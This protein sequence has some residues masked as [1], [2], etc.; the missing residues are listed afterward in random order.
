MAPD[1]ITIL[2]IED[3]PAHAELVRRAFQA[4]GDRFDLVTVSTLT[5]AFKLI[6]TKRPD[7]IITDWALPDGDGGRLLSHAQSNGDLPVIVMTSYGN[8]QTAVEAMRSGALD[9][10]VK[11]AE[12]MSD[13]PHVAERA[14]REWQ[15]VHDRRVAEEALRESEVRFRTLSENAPDIVYTLSHDGR[16]TY[17]NP[18]WEKI[19]GHPAYEVMGRPLTEFVAEEDRDDVESLLIRVCAGPDAIQ[20][21]KGAFLHKN[22]TRRI[23]LVSCGPNVNPEGRV[24]GAVGLLKD[25]TA[26][27]QLESQLLQSQKMEALGTLAGGVAHE[28]NNVL[29]AIKGYTQLMAIDKEMPESLRELLD[30]IDEAT[31]RARDLT[32]KLLTFSRI[33]SGVKTAVDINTV[34]NTVVD[35][36]L[37]TFPRNIKVQLNL[38]KD[39]GI[40]SANSTQLEQVVLNLSLNAKD[41]MPDGGELTFTTAPRRLDESFCRVNPWA[42]PGHYV[43]LSVADAGS[44]IAPHD[45]TRIFEPF[46]TTKEAEKGTGLGLSVAYS[47]IRSHSGGI[48]VDSRPANGTRFDLFFP[49]QEVPVEEV[50]DETISA[51]FIKGQGEHVLV[52]DDEDAVRE[53]T[54]SALENF[55]YQVD[56]ATNG[57]EALK[58]VQMAR[59]ADRPYHLILL[60]LAMPIMDGR[61][62]YHR[63]INQDA[64]PRILIA[65][66]HLSD[67]ETFEEKFPQAMGL[68]QKPFDLRTLLDEVHK[69]LV[70]PAN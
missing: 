51:P 59:D 31:G 42:T 57:A 36:I 44:G 3:E 11:S 56:E 7:L 29:T 28:F 22:G 20:G 40:I 33:E 4:S 8:E 39:I 65:T 53:V 19:L 54:R 38:D 26:T 32:R 66:G 50:P 61:E 14:L 16:F 25:I 27:I 30:K 5:G 10:V 46:Y 70:E 9:Y 64:P 13:M 12:A 35:L 37:H 52:V 6:E 45:V 69:T 17:V 68:L 23:F 1:P 24:T 18:A 55:G 48:L 58:A 34:V 49:I 47:I 41:A 15:L 67:R 60:D 43:V 2:L 62:C 63:L 21:L